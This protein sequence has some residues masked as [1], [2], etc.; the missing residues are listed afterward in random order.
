MSVRFKWPPD[1]AAFQFGS[2]LIWALYSGG[3]GGIPI[4]ITGVSPLSLVNA[5]AGNI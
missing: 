1:L 2:A 5:I 4:T 3:G